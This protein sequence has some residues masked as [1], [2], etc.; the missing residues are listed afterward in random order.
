LERPFHIADGHRRLGAEDLA[1]DG[2][3]QRLRS[4]HTS[5]RRLPGFSYRRKL[6]IE[7]GG[8][9]ALLGEGREFNG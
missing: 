1:E 8:D 2:S 4:H 5:F 3:L 9:A 6:A 7:D